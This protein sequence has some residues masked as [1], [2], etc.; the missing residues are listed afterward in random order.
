MLP[1][2]WIYFQMIHLIFCN[3]ISHVFN[4][5]SQSVRNWYYCEVHFDGRP[6]RRPP[7]NV[8]NLSANMTML[9]LTE[10]RVFGMS[11]QNQKAPKFRVAGQ[12]PRSTRDS[13]K[14]V[15]AFSNLLLQVRYMESHIIN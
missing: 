11:T 6:T 15:F 12:A 9:R 2:R 3:K 4:D 14:K 13:W 1:A 5:A 10:C 7:P 8:K